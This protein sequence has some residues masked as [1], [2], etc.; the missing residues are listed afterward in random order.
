MAS[1]LATGPPLDRGP[2][3]TDRQPRAVDDVP[4]D[5]LRLPG[6]R[7]RCAWSRR[8]R[9]RQHCDRWTCP[10]CRVVKGHEWARAIEQGLRW[11]DHHEVVAG[12][13]TFTD[14]TDRGLHLAAFNKRFSRFCSNVRRSG[15]FWDHYVSALA[16]CPTSGRLHR[17]VVALGG[18]YLPPSV[19]AD[20]AARAHLGYVDARRI[21][22]S[23]ADRARVANYVACDGVRFALAHAG[24]AA[25]IQPFS[26]SQR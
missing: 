19:L 20:H 9:G 12:L 15:A 4:D 18:P 3:H 1:V 16:V 24:T 23:A 7:P 6:L 11:A 26:R 25:R 10:S 2:E 5:L 21:R 14:G 13:V 8:T 17:H 22:R